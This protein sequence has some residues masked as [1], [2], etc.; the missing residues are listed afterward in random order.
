MEV[1]SRRP[2]GTI[3]YGPGSRYGT[4]GDVILRAELRSARFGAVDHPSKRVVFTRM[5]EVVIGVPTADA[6]LEFAERFGAHR[7][8][9]MASG[10]LSRET[11][12]VARLRNNLGERFAG[13][14]D[15]MP[16]HTP[17]GAV[18]QAAA[19]AR[20]LR[21]DLVVSVGGGSVTDAAKAVRFALGTGLRHIAVPTTLSAGE[22]SSIAG[23]TNE[24]TST[25]ELLQDPALIPTAVVL[26]PA[27]TL[28]TPE[29]L[30]LST[31][32]RAIDH[33]VEGFCANEAHAFGRAQSLHALALLAAGLSRVRTN[34]D[35][36][37]A[38]LDC[39][40]GA[41][42]SMGAVATGVPMGASHGIGYVL[43]AAYGVPHGH[44]SCV[45][46]PA[47]L[48]W[49]RPVTEHLQ[50]QLATAI[51]APGADVAD[52][53]DQ[54]IRGLGLPRTLAAVGI[55]REQYP[56]IAELAMT[57]SWVPR[58][59]RKIEFPVQVWEI[60]ELASHP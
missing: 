22:F 37:E 12:E 9:V 45:M 16:A 2:L 21:A 19:L 14:F 29:W 51:G 54:L 35:D 23:V 15:R 52:V 5:E 44:T 33:C 6:V 17:R 8:L 50:A 59:P 31:G 10:T 20:E 57:T 39:L 42:L 48:R 36:L 60:L 43:G 38:R 25:K 55:G 30:W 7:V 47:V 49:N 58:N 56:R 4:L 28:H 18:A 11:G 53:L 3:G 26:D 41:W 46:L 13:L 27:I 24:E 34:P 32:I 1:S 40:Q